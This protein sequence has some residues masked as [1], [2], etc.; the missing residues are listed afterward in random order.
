MKIGILIAIA[1]VCV[2]CGSNASRALEDKEL[3]D[4]LQHAKD[5]GL[6]G[7]TAELD[8]LIPKFPSDQNAAPI[9]EKIA[10]KKVEGVPESLAGELTKAPTKML[11]EKAKEV[12]KAHSALLAEAD[13]AIKLPHC[14]FD[15][16]WSHSSI[17]F[18][19][20]W[21]AVSQVARL[22]SIQGALGYSEGNYDETCKSLAKAWKLS[23]HLGEVPNSS[24]QMFSRVIQRRAFGLLAGWVVCHPERAELCKLLDKFGQEL[25]VVNPKND[26]KMMLVSLLSLIDL[27]QTDEGRKKLGLRSDDV[28]TII[29]EAGQEPATGSPDKVAIIKAARGYWKALGTDSKYIDMAIEASAD[30]IKKLLDPY[31]LERYLATQTMLNF[32]HDYSVDINESIA[33]KLQC[34]ALARATEGG[35]VQVRIKTDDLKSPWTGE[36]LTYYAD[37]SLV[38]INIKRGAGSDSLRLTIKRQAG[39]R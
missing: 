29:K 19:P 13:K 25:S 4:Q 11:Q 10:Q 3:K 6:P 34:K 20:E 30:E 2:S 24:A 22:Y 8:Q 33:R 23:K 28:E 16:A 15:R 7:T 37:A 38:Q 39:E 1:C 36:P 12:L 21:I 27:C 26:Q 9:Y 35:K 5:E 14:R 17:E 32:R 31:P 18:S